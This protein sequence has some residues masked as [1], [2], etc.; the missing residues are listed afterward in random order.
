M[1]VA[2]IA[3]DT[4]SL[5]EVPL[6]KKWT[7]EECKLLEK[8]GLAELHRYELIEGELVEKVGKN[9]PHVYVLLL[10]TDWLRTV[11]K[12]LCVVP[13]A[14]ID[15]APLDQPTS[16]P[17][18]DAIVLK[19]P[20]GRYSRGVPPTEILL[21]AEIADTTIGF[22]LSTK[23]R[24]YARAGISDY[25]VL[26]VRNRRVIVHRNPVDGRYQSVESYATDEPISPLHAPQASVLVA[27]F[28]NFDED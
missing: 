19:Q 10:L 17:E 21:L 7:R 20:Y 1:P 25:W 5:A 15:V 28:F 11:F 23:A 18:P 13:E 4:G 26:D 14:P 12:S 27:S 22:D 24:L 6:H 2:W 3:P 8:A 16:A 9:H